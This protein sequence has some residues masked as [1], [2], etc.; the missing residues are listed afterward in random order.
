MARGSD[1]TVGSGE[2][3]AAHAQ[4]SAAVG[5]EASTTVPVASPPS[6]RRASSTQHQES[7]SAMIFRRAG[8]RVLGMGLA[9]G[10]AAGLLGGCSSGEDVSCTLDSCTVTLDRGVDAKASVLGVGVEL[11]E[12]TKD[13]VI[14]EVGGSRV[15]VPNG[16]SQVQASG[17]SVKVDKLTDSQVV[18]AVSRGGEG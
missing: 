2:G 15:S 16:G 18:L 17:L 5:G 11:V 12:V 14:V 10:L 1:D 8:F 6:R 9:V 4:A 13:Q 3:D 7:E